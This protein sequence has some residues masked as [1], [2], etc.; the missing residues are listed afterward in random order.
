MPP[1]DF[2]PILTMIPERWAKWKQLIQRVKGNH[3]TLYN[4]ML[5]NVENRLKRG[6]GIGVFMEE[7][8]QNAEEW[9][10]SDRDLLMLG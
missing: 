7:A 3:R 9:G 1:V 6:Q 2:F 8:I 10:F 4:R 5:S